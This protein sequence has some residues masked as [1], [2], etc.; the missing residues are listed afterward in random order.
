MHYECI[1]CNISHQIYLYMLERL[2]VCSVSS[3]TLCL[4]VYTWVR[5]VRACVC[6]LFKYF[7]NNSYCLVKVSIHSVAEHEPKSFNNWDVLWQ[8][9]LVAP[10]FGCSVCVCVPK[11]L[12]YTFGTY[13][14]PSL[15]WVA[16]ATRKSD[17]VHSIYKFHTPH[18]AKI[19]IYGRREGGRERG[20]GR[21]RDAMK[22]MRVN[23]RAL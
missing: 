2:S 20:G 21:T 10:W 13:I 19:F 9:S 5:C 16:G 23:E 8:Y 3:R 6:M 11:Q 7:D 17:G 12:M 14:M 1:L 22:R 18:F 15:R 4:S